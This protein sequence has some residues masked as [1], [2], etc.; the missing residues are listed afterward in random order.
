[1]LHRCTH[2]ALLVL[3]AISLATPVLAKGGRPPAEPLDL[4]VL[5][6]NDDGFDSDGI[7][8]V[9]DALLAAGHRVTLVGPADQQS[10]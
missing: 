10:G 8:A 1:M 7:M 5:L 4:H 6:T 9:R 2:L 3:L